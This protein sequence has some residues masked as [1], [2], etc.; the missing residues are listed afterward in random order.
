V[1]IPRTVGRYEIVDLIG[2]GAIGT[3]YRARDPRIGRYVAIKLLKPE[4]DT[5]E[6]R[7]R[8]S[9]EAVSAGRLSHPNIVTI[10]DVGEHDGLPFIAMEY[11]RGETFN[12]LL[13]LRPPLPVL[14]KVQLVEEVCA[15]LAH[16]HEAGIVHRDIKPANL[17][18]GPEGT[19]KILGFGMAKLGASETTRAGTIAGTLNY[20]S[21]E[22]VKGVS[23][24]ARAD[25][26]AVGAV[27]YEL[28]SHQQAFPGSVP[29]EV[30]SRILEGVPTPLLEF[31][32]DI[33]PRLVSVVDRALEKD[34]DV[35]FQDVSVLQ[36]ELTDIRTTPMAAERTRSDLRA[37]V[38]AVKEAVPVIAY[39]VPAER[40]VTRARARQIEEHL[41]NA[42]LAFDAGDY[43]AAIEAC[44]KVLILDASEERA[45]A[46]L[47][48]IH[49]AIDEH[50]RLVRAAEAQRQQ[51]QARARAAVDAARRRFAKGDHQGALQSLETLDLDSD[52]LVAGA[53]AELREAYR[54]I[55]ERRRAEKDR[56]ERLQRI[57]TL[58][59]DVRTALRE[60][61]LEDASQALELLRDVDATGPELSDLAE[62]VNR[63]HAVA[64]LNEQLEHLLRDFDQ[65]LQQSVLPSALELLK[66]VSSLAPTDARVYEAR[67]RYEQAAAAVA[68]REA[69]E[70]R[71]RQAEQKLDEAAACL[72]KGDL[73]ATKGLLELA[74]ELAPDHP[75][76]AAL[77]QQLQEAIERQAAAEAAER[78][79]QQIAELIRSASH[80][81]EST[82]DQATDLVFALREV[83]EALALEPANAEASNLKRVIEDSIAAHREAARVKATITNARARFA[84]GKY[85]AALKLLEDFQ[86]S[87][88]E[89][90]ATLADLCSA[91]QQIEEQRRLEQERIQ[92]QQRIATILAEAQSALEDR[93]FEVALDVLSRAAETD[94]DA[95]EIAALTERARRE[96]A[97]AQ[98]DAELK[99]L[100]RDLDDR[101]AAGDLAGA[102]E[103]LKAATGFDAADGRVQAA[104]QRLETAVAARQAEEARVR[105]LEEVQTAAEDLLERGDTEGAVTLLKRAQDLNALHPRTMLLSERVE[106]AVRKR[107]AAEAAERIRRTVDDLLAAAAEDLHA[108]QDGQRVT[109]A[110]EKIDRALVLIPDDPGA[111]ALHST[112]KDA[113][114]EQRQ[115]AI[116]RAGVRN[117]R[118]RFANGKHHAALQLLESLD[119]ASNPLVAETLKEL[120]EELHRIEEQRRAE[121]DLADRNGRTASLMNNA[122]VAIAEERFAEALDALSAVRMID[123][124][125]EGLSELTRQ[126]SERQAAATAAAAEA[127]AT[128]VIL[129]PGAQPSSTPLEEG[130]DGPGTAQ[131]LTVV[132]APP[133][134]EPEDLGVVPRPWR[135]RLIVAVGAL[136]LA[137]LVALLRPAWLVRSGHPSPPPVSRP[138][139]SAVPEAPPR[140]EVAPLPPH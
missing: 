76:A 59:E 97:A 29:D 7:D 136:L 88:A 14:R 130:S 42:A 64:R 27:L 93:R 110:M 62:R 51:Q 15:G 1:D 28:L 90:V 20:M 100:L 137:I 118:S 66:A 85:Q 77:S 40:G 98:L 33:D 121:Q 105:E 55:E 70:A 19:V 111:L 91:L 74:A 36:R 72:E 71:H 4:F 113:L 84:I 99:K 116:V 46:Q 124:K 32:P 61:R 3:L 57:R 94:P 23:V 60:N 128:R 83:N 89:I 109:A 102:A 13:E 107:A 56:L 58:A 127:D 26:F 135:W 81:L 49:A 112:A 129:P 69:A 2:H 9:R 54:Q 79:R 126:V 133:P 8:F 117:A 5:P 50:Q 48:R 134:E 123:A 78:L 31:C 21:P 139:P 75:R 131:E 37:T 125:A 22:Q 35:R 65:Q 104:S 138:A 96:Q 30:L 44:K 120:R 73:V 11:V 53:L 132:V 34:P 67:K 63:A 87:Q 92:K 86:P 17:V 80:R 43:D 16:A 101:L 106:E 12:D 18:V 45:L 108:D 41:N 52:P 114:A 6:L 115:A 24:D 38:A 68:A 10:Y 47:D 119:P 122:R 25:I 103:V 140:R 95:P 82:G 39:P